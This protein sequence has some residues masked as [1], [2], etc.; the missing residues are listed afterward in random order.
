VS[1][2]LLQLIG[3]ERNER[4]LGELRRLHREAADE[5]PAAG[6]VELGREQ[7]RDEER[8]GARHQG[9]HDGGRRNR[10]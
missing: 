1:F 2:L 6:V 8:Q 10:R 7:H 9:V 3:E 4:E 5:E